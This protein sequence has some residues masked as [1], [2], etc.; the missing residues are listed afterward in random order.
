M[1]HRIAIVPGGGI[2]DM[3]CSLPIVDFLLA[4]FAETCEVDVC[5]TREPGIYAALAGAER[6]R[7]IAFVYPGLPSKEYHAI[8]QLHEFVN[9]QATEEFMKQHVSFFPYYL[10]NC[11]RMA[12][13]NGAE[14]IFPRAQN[15]VA[16]LAVKMGYDR[17]TFPQWTLGMTQGTY[18]K[19]TYSGKPEVFLQDRYITI[20]DGWNSSDGAARPTKAWAPERWE[21]FVRAARCAGIYTVQLGALSNGR[22]YDV[23]LQLRGKTSFAECLGVLKGSACHV[24]IEGGLMH[25]AAA[26]GTRAVILHGSTNAAFFSYSGLHKN[27]QTGSCQNCWWLSRDWASRCAAGTSAACMRH[28]PERV[29]Q[30]VKDI[31]RASRARRAA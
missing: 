15:Q 18:P 9:I 16:N 4:H 5:F 22:S 25:A 26:L 24:D 8:F 6:M 29:L 14:V 17:V 21:E 30:Y 2:G 10:T 20:N 1:K 7:Q 27:V 31:L 19:L 28:S 13:L 23:D 3:I 11:E 12:Q